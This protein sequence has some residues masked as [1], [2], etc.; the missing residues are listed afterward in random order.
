MEEMTWSAIDLILAI[1]LLL[2]AWR[3][4]RKGLIIEI[5]TLVGLVAGLFAGYYGADRVADS[6]ADSW[7]LKA[8]TLHGIGFLIAFAAVLVAVYL[9]GKVIEKAVDLVALGLVN[10]GLGALFGLAKMGLLLSVAI[11]FLNLA[12]GKDEWLPKEQVEQAV[13]YPVVSDAASWL[14]PEMS[15][16]GFLERAREQ[17]EDGLENLREGVDALKDR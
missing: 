17:A 15:Q 5:A 4:F 16:K 11:Y 1:P 2:A 13:L 7:D 12:F 10:K 3:G 6:L 9:L 14:V 8:S